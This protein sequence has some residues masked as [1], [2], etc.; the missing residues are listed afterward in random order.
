MME[1][2]EPLIG[3][4]TVESNHQYS[5]L[6]NHLFDDSF[7][8]F[9]KWTELSLAT[10]IIKFASNNKINKIGFSHS[11]YIKII[12]PWTSSLPSSRQRIK[13]F[14][15]DSLI[16]SK[17]SNVSY[18][19]FT[20]FLFFLYYCWISWYVRSVL[21]IQVPL[22][23]YLIMYLA[24]LVFQALLW[25]SW[26]V[27]APL[28]HVLGWFLVRDEAEHMPMI[29]WSMILVDEQLAC[30]KLDRLNSYQIS[31]VYRTL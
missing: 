4:R 17:W 20:G 26:S 31:I 30:K 18:I 5:L 25:I 11:I 19:F 1:L 3:V 29:T 15:I 6:N 7:G 21:I 8:H 2:D 13:S 14:T 27:Y 24:Q 23:Y 16:L 28:W 9:L 10:R 12:L 22:Q